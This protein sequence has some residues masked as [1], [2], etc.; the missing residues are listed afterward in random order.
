MY[1]YTKFHNS[2]HKV[3]SLE[4]ALKVLGKWLTLNDVYWLRA[5]ARGY[6]TFSML[7]STDEEILNAHKY[8]N[9]QK[10]WLFLSSGK[11][12]MLFFRS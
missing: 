3:P 11:P 8:I 1:K 2:K 6:K 10:I 4:K 7:N 5:W 9:I 12:R